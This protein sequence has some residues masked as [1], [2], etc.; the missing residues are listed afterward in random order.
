MRSKSAVNT[1]DRWPFDCLIRQRIVAS[2]KRIAAKPILLGRYGRQYRWYR[3]F[4]YHASMA[5]HSYASGCRCDECRA[6]HAKR[7]RDYRAKNA[8]TRN[9]PHSSMRRRTNVIAMPTTQQPQAPAALVV[10]ANE[11]ATKAQCEMSK[12]ADE[13]PSVVQQC[14][15]LSRILDDPAQSPMWPTTSRQLQAL[16]TQ[17]AGPK[18]KSGGRLASVQSMTR[19]DRRVAVNG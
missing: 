14:I 10:G 8:K 5:G 4:G 13:M 3:V 18:K 6:K 9:I 15:S 12:K 16:L 19:R 2:P 7:Q 1:D 11:A 17:L